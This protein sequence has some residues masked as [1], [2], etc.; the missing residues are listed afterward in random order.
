MILLYVAFKVSQ[1]GDFLFVGFELL[2]IDAAQVNLNVHKIFLI[3]LVN[4]GLDLGSN[5]IPFKIKGLVVRILP[6]SELLVREMRLAK[7]END[8]VDDIKTDFKVALIV[9][10]NDQQVQDSLDI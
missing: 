2:S 4:K 3:D 1:G 7:T 6:F 9:P 5:V 8:V 10:L